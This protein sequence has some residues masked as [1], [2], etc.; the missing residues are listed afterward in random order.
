MAANTIVKT[1]DDLNGVEGAAPVHFSYKGRYYVIDLTEENE[2]KFERAIA[3]YVNAARSDHMGAN[4]ARRSRRQYASTPT[5]VNPRDVRT[6]AANNGIE[7]GTHGRLPR[8]LI[9]QFLASK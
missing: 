1:L 8:G 7:V 4:M 6:W 2:A 3:R 5:S 9:E